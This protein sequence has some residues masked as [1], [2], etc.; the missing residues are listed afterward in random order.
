MDSMAMSPPKV[1]CADLV[2]M[3]AFPPFKT[4]GTG[5][6]LMAGMTKFPM[7]TAKGTMTRT[8]P[9][10]TDVTVEVTNLGKMQMYPIHVHEYSCANQSGGGHYK[11]DPSMMM[12]AESNE[13]WLPI[14]MT[15]GN[16]AGSAM[17]S[18]TDHLARPEAASIVVHDNTMNNPRLA[19]IDL[20]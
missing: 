5:T 17:V 14:M 20:K 18:I 13:I 8:F 11:R 12:A 4:E 6:L 1:A 19:C 3:E 9:M 10:T 15:D 2:R 16:G 7:G